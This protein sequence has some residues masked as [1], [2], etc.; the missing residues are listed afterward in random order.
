MESAT[1][2][3]GT[4]LPKLGKLLLKEYNLKN[5]VKKG[6]G[7][8]KAELEAMQVA[9]EKISNVPLDKL[10]TQV[11]LWANEVRELSFVIEDSL[12]SSMVHIFTTKGIY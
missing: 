3:L 12:D 4:L 6:I 11:K 1:G 7:N 8:L 5:T 2:A 10:D 9:L